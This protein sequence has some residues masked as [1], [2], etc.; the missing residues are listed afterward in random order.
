MDIWFF[1]HNLLKM[2]LFAHCSADWLVINQVSI[3][4]AFCFCVLSWDSLVYFSFLVPILH[5]MNCCLFIVTHKFCV[6]YF[7]VFF[8]SVWLC[9]VFCTSINIEEI[10][11]SGSLKN[12]ETNK[13]PPGILNE[14]ALNLRVKFGGRLTSLQYWLPNFPIHACCILLH[15]GFICS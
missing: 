10:S 14:I 3:F 4:V 6:V 8:K 13:N 11:F 5:C 12:K 9:L 7:I 15:S 2:T 1:H